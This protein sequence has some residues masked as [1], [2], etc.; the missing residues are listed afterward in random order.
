[1]KRIEPSAALVRKGITSIFLSSAG[2]LV[3]FSSTPSSLCR[4][5]ANVV[6]PSPGGP[7]K[8]M[9]GSGSPRFLRGGQ[10]IASRSA[11]APL[12]D[13]LA[14]PLRAELL[15]D[16]V[17]GTAARSFAWEADRRSSAFHESSALAST[18]PPRLS[19]IEESERALSRHQ[20]E[21][22]RAPITSDFADRSH[23]SYRR[24]T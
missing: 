7:S 15:V 24:R 16:R 21:A 20:L 3:M 13:H 1:M 2:P 9:C 5:V 17:G 12:A 10:A 23:Q 11:T 6:L 14:E 19:L 22:G 18:R 4:T 8:R